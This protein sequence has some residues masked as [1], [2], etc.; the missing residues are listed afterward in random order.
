[1][2]ELRDRIRNEQV[3]NGV[4]VMGWCH[5]L[6]F[7]DRAPPRHTMIRNPGVDSTA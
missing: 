7:L 6:G 5:A 1:M 3:G 2:I 4:H